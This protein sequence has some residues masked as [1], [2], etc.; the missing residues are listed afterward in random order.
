MIKYL[1]YSM[2]Q[3]ES[4]PRFVQSNLHGSAEVT[5]RVTIITGMLGRSMSVLA[6]PGPTMNCPHRY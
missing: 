3:K 2:G 5:K 4:S 6:Q 1:V